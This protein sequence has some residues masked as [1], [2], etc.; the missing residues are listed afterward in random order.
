MREIKEFQELDEDFKE[1]QKEKWQV[2]EKVAEMNSFRQEEERRTS[3]QKE[4]ISR[5]PRQ[6]LG[7]PE[8]TARTKS[9]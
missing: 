8:E 1:S 6:E 5:Q 2:Q 7:R 3:Q 9:G 4:G